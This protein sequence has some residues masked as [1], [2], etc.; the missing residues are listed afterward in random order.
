MKTNYHTHTYRCNHAKGR[1]EEYVLAAIENGYTVLGFSDHTPWPYR[2]QDFIPRIRMRLE[3]FQDYLESIHFLKEKYKDQIEIVVGVEAEYFKEYMGW[4]EKQLNQGV[5][6]YAIFGNHYGQSDE[7][8]GRGDYF[9]NCLH[10]KE[11]LEL[12]CDTMIQG[13]ETGLFHYIAHPDLFCR[14][15]GSFDA[16]CKDISKKICQKAKEYNCLLELN[17]S[18]FTFAQ[19]HG[20]PGYPHPEFWKI[21]KEVGNRVILGMDA[22]SPQALATD[23][24]R[25]TGVHLAERLGLELVDHFEF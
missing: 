12:Y 15:D 6:D 8:T 17:V 13:I 2:N 11:G 19:H 5:I 14:T 10:T 20:T 16:H 1:D 9:G 22:H 18:G 21:A 4:L 24:F 3:E 25:N 23:E 7:Y